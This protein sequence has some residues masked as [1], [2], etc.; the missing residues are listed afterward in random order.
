MPEIPFSFWLSVLASR[1]TLGNVSSGGTA[2][3]RAFLLTRDG[4]GFPQVISQVG[5][6][7]HELTT[8]AGTLGACRNA[9]G[10]RAAARRQRIGNFRIATSNDNGRA[11]IR[12]RALIQRTS[13]QE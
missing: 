2:F 11:H 7:T 6:T 8:T 5:D 13:Q 3:D 12:I 10:D 4:A 1:Q 9:V